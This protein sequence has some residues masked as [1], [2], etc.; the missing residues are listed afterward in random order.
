MKQTSTL[1]ICLFAITFCYAQKPKKQSS[2][3]SQ[4]RAT[5]KNK[6]LDKQWYLGFKAGIN[7]S[8]ADPIK[9][10]TVVTP[11]N[12]T[13]SATDKVYNNFSKVGS[14]ATLEITFVY[15]G[16]SIST[17]PTYRNS[18]FTYSNQFEWKS[19]ENTN[20]HLLLKYDQSQK[21]DYADF[22]L[23]VKYEITGDK[24]KPYVQVGIFYSMLVNAT[25][26]VKVSGTDYASGGINQFSN[27]PV[28][29]GAKDLFDNYWGLMAGIGAY[30]NLG[31]VRLVLDASYHK[32]MSNIANVKN[33]FGND[34][35]SGIG[36]AQDDLKLNNIV[37][38]A[39]V[40]F[41]LRF[42]SKGYKS[43]E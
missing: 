21:V 38:S 27:E 19:T 22:P 33:R 37:I 35:L 8:Q 39:G 25:K 2:F 31:N 12:Y 11:T 3:N 18:T 20:D 34:R 43:L 14:H 26:T 9:R 6:F 28:I 16:F 5:Q 17:Q 36:D 42:L 40:V 24:L 23:I 32:G 7:I 10:Y 1:L 30:Y 41:P 4:N 13:P 15:K 29:V